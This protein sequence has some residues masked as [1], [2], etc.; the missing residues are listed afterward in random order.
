[1]VL[2]L[3]PVRLNPVALSRVLLRVLALRGRVI[4]VLPPP[5]LVIGGSAV[6]TTNC[7]H[8]KKGMSVNVCI[9]KKNECV[10]PSYPS[11]LILILFVKAKE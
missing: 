8:F 1:M 6:G 4:G 5:K 2:V 3:V 11:L 7:V 9:S 10:C